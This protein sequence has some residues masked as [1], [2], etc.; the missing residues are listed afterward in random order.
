MKNNRATHALKSKRIAFMA[1]RRIA[2]MQGA[3]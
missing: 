3:Y 2:R 1:H